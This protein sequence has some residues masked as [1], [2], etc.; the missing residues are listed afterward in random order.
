[1][2]GKKFTAA[3]KHFYKKEMEYRKQINALKASYLTAQAALTQAN[4][5]IKTLLESQEE[6]KSQVSKL[7][8]YTKLSEDDIKLACK[9]DQ[10]IA[11]LLSALRRNCI[12]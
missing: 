12:I 10:E 8:E 9:K 2:K 4:E 11:G 3:E 6:L 5:K 1:M 7:L